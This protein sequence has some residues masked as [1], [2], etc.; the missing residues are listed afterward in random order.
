MSS[1]HPAPPPTP[2]RESVFG[3]KDVRALMIGTMIV[4]GLYVVL[5]GKQ[6]LDRFAGSPAAS[7]AQRQAPPRFTLI[8]DTIELQPAKADGRKWDVGLDGLPD[9]R[10]TIVNRTLGARYASATRRDVLEAEFDERTVP[11]R[12]GDELYLRVEDEDVQLDDLVGEHRLRLTREMI[13]T[14]ELELT[15]GQV[16]RLT[17]RFGSP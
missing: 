5:W 3:R 10:I 4:V 1:T 9:P 8:L 2:R 14:G 13:D 17:L 16:K 12:E 15:F 6:T 11:V 7:Q